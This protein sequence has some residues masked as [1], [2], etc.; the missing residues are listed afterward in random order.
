MIIA[1]IAV[2]QAR[3]HLLS[4][5]PGLDSPLRFSGWGRRLSAVLEFAET[6]YPLLDTAFLDNE[7][8]W[9]NDSGFYGLMLCTLRTW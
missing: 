1:H 6:L 9:H 4:S 5:L 8:I 7:S 3:Y 2:L